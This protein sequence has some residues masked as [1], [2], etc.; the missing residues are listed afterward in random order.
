MEV[1]YILE[2]NFAYILKFHLNKFEKVSKKR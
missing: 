2:N 1:F